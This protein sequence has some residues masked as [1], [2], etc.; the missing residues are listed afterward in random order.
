MVL[1]LFYPLRD[2]LGL[3]ALQLSREL[4]AR[5]VE[6]TILTRRID[7]ATPVDES[8][9]GI[10]IH[11]VWPHGSRSNL[12]S[13]LEILPMAWFLITRRKSFD[14]IHVQDVRSIFIS[15]L[16]ARWLT[17]KP[18]IVKVPTQGDVLR[19]VTESTELTRFSKALRKFLLPNAIW[20]RLL[21][22]AQGWIATTDAIMDE[23]N[24][25]GVGDI[26]RQIPNGIDTSRFHPVSAD[27]KIVLRKRLGLPLDHKI[28]IS[29]GRL[30]PRKGLDHVIQA[31]SDLNARF[32]NVT[33]FFPGDV[34]DVDLD[35]KIR[36]EALVKERGLMD[37]V[38]MPGPVANVEEYL[39][40]SDMFVMISEREGLSN[41]MLEAM[42]SGLSII[43][44]NIGGL[45]QLITHETS[46]LVVQP[47]DVNAL[48]EQLSRYLSDESFANDMGAG[49][50]AAIEESFTSR[51]VAE[52]YLDL[53]DDL[54]GDPPRAAAQ[55]Q[56]S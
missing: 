16:L 46:G 43:A 17:R 14:I 10:H 8:L 6:V 36:L 22:Q 39:Q 45:S 53:Y 54:I 37:V 24:E 9:D 32:P 49:A 29:H 2:G 26:A 1:D 48:R 42:A 40:A 12:K 55:A 27:D 31:I 18:L 25:C 33:L 44:S 4:T 3:Q 13:M 7:P 50:L 35:Y 20:R 34:S 51:R 15:G 11:R 19:Q 30:D 21:R 38:H 23:L 47:G 52:Q 56:R 5:G 28:I 41:A